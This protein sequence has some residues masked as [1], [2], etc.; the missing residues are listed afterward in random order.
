MR[1]SYFTLLD[2]V[3]QATKPGGNVLVMGYPDIFAQTSISTWPICNGIWWEDANR[4]RGWAADLNATI[5]QAV[6]DFGAGHPGV[7]FTF[8]NIDDQAV[9]PGD[10]QYLWEPPGT[11]TTHALCGTST[12]WLNGLNLGDFSTTYKISYHL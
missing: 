7:H 10:A 8:L 1:G 2:K 3:L 5:G 4:I 6:K 12:P 11:T 9:A